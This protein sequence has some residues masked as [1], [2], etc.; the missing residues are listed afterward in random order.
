MNRLLADLAALY[1][2]DP[3]FELLTNG[4]VNF[5]FSKY[6]DA[7]RAEYWQLMAKVGREDC[8]S[9]FDFGTVRVLH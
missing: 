7:E 2:Q 9:G 4:H 6:T 3:D 1:E 8:G 5:N